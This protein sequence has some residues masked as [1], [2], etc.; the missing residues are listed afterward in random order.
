MV[1]FAALLTAVQGGYQGA[2]MA[3]TEVLAAQHYLGMVDLVDEAGMKPSPVDPG[4]ARGQDG[5]FGGD[6]AD[7]VRPAVRMA[8]LTGKQASV[9]FTAGPVRPA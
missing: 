3:P 4:T 2:V 5:L 8:L 9:N 6:A 7:A 1:A